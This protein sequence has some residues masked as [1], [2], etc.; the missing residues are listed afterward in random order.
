M[1]DYLAPVTT[2]A[3]AVMGIIPALSAFTGRKKTIWISSIGVVGFV[4][5]LASI[6]SI[7]AMHEDE[8]QLL[9]GDDFLTV[10]AAFADPNNIK[11]SFPLF[12]INKQ[13]VPVY[14]VILQIIN[15][16]KLNDLWIQAEAGR[17]ST[18]EII[19]ATWPKPISV[20]TVPAL[21]A[22]S[23]RVDA[24]L[25]VGRYQIQIQTRRGLFIEA[26]ALRVE[27]GKVRECYEV[28]RAGVKL[29]SNGCPT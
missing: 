19:D 10:T 8:R 18:A 26:S 1:W 28:M 6:F 17:G 27:D 24:A 20:G 4:S 5:L 29:A 11:G 25:P 7:R 22:L 13:P 23:T 15:K 14:D 9:G 12:I 16:D 21:N 3:L 2:I